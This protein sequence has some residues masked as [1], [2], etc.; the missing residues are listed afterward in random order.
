MKIEGSAQVRRTEKSR[1]A[2]RAGSI[3]ARFSDALSRMLG[4]GQG[5]AGV[6]GPGDVTGVEA[7]LALQS[8]ESADDSPRGRKLKAHARAG[9]QLDALELLRRDLLTGRLSPKALEDLARCMAEGRAELDDPQLTEI[10]DEIDLR[11]Q[12]ELAKLGVD[13]TV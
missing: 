12:V 3:G 8:A 1:K 11:V 5:P 2:D 4:T 9:R 13:V 10:L 6:E 7:L